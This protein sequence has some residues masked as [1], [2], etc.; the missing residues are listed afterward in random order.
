MAGAAGLNPDSLSQRYRNW[1]YYPTWV[2]PPT[3]L[4]PST[5]PH[6]CNAS[7]GIGCKTDVFQLIQLE[8]EIATGKYRG[9]YLQFDGVGYE[10]YMAS[11]TDM[12][13]FNL[14]DPGVIFSPRAGRPPLSWN[15]TPGMF[16]YGGA[17]FV[18]PVLEDYR[19]SA[20]RVL[21]ASPSDGK[22]YYAYFGS[23]K[24]GYEPPPGASGFASSKDGLTWERAIPLPFM[25]T[26]PA[27]GARPWEQG[28]VYAPFLIPTPDGQLASFYNAGS[29]SRNEQS[30]AAYLAAGIAGLPGFDF[31][32]N[33]SQWVR[34]PLNPT[35]PN[36]A[37][38]SFQAADPKVFFDDEQQVWALIYFCNGDT[39]HGADICIAFS[40]DQRHWDKA[41]TPIYQHGGH[42][43]GLDACHA[44]KAWLMGSRDGTLYLYYTGVSG[45]DCNTRGILLLTSQPLGP[46]ALSP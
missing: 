38:A 4:N 36:D 33:M 43:G 8:D 10:T 19:V 18:G 25:D 35:L 29:P 5:C 23:P 27:N 15:A 17:T 12:V 13:H 22:Y 40:N 7:T 26:N 24:Y 14:N 37:V 9:V 20:G 42:P 44:H 16:D 30:G 11:T 3:C 39:T 46:A 28:Q 31:D 45:P 34:D 32:Y 1:T 6:Y 21:K 2:V 41:A